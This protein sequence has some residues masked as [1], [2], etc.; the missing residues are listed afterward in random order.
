[1]KLETTTDRVMAYL[2][3]G[4]ASL[5]QVAQ[6]LGLEERLARAAIDGLLKRDVIEV[7]WTEKSTGP[8]MRSFYAITGNDDK[9]KRDTSSIVSTALAARGELERVWL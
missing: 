8:G 4:P 2:E 1:M 3:L 7:A 5:V 6:A 9:P